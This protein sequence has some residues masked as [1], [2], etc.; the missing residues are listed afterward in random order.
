MKDEKIC[1]TCKKLFTLPCKD[2]E[3]HRSSHIPERGCARC[4]HE[5][6]K[7]VLWSDYLMFYKEQD[8]KIMQFSHY[9]MQ[10]WSS[11]MNDKIKQP[12]KYELWIDLGR[13][14]IPCDTK[15]AVVEKWSDPDFKITKEEWKRDGRTK[16]RVSRSLSPLLLRQLETI[17]VPR[18]TSQRSFTHRSQGPIRAN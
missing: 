10:M 2:Y 11:Y 5:L 4:I 1:K 8:D 18:V 15:Q 13:V 3:A 14:I 9:C 16:S 7:Y 6:K 17:R 12:I